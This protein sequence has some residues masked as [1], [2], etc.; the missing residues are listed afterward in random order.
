MHAGQERDRVGGQ[1]LGQPGQRGVPGECV[2]GLLGA[3]G[4]EGGDRGAVGHRAVWAPVM[5]WTRTFRADVTV[6]EHYTGP[7]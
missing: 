6:S 2:A 3:P 7:G 1:M 4:E 5:G